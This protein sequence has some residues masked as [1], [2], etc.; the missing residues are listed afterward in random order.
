MPGVL[1]DINRAMN[2]RPSEVAGWRAVM[3]DARAEIMRLEATVTTW[4]HVFEGIEAHIKDRINMG[5]AAE[6][7]TYLSIIHSD[8]ANINRD[9]E[10][11]VNARWADHARANAENRRLR[12]ELKDALDTMEDCAR[13]GGAP[14][15]IEWGALRAQIA[16]TKRAL[17]E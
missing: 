13:H 11:I 15:S 2:T 6:P 14:E 17:G 12:A 10:A 4:R 16:V 8:V 1:D 5:D 9:S 3:H 7:E